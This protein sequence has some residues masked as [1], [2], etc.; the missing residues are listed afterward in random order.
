MLPALA[1]FLA[2]I[3]DIGFTN[4]AVRAGVLGAIG[5]KFYIRP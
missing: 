5:G 3:D 2:P 1:P 4:V